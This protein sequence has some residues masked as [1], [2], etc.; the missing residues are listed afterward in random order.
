MNNLGRR[1]RIDFTD[2]YRFS[3]G[4]IAGIIMF[5]PIYLTVV[6]GFKSK[7]Q[8]F[9]NPFGL[10][11]PVSLEA[12]EA[13]LIRGQAYWTFLFNSVV[14]VAGVLL[15]ILTFSM[16]AG[17]AISRLSFRGNVLLYNFFIMG[18]LFPLTVA[19][20]PLYLQMKSLNLLG[21]R[22]GVILAEAAFNYPLSIF[23]FTGFFKEIPRDLQDACYIDGGGPLMFF[24]RILVPLSRP[25]I[26]TVSI[27]VFIMSWNQFLLPLLVLSDSGTFT[28]PLGV[29]QFQG[30][31]T[32]GWNF[33]MAFITISIL[34]MAVFYFTLQRQI[35]SGL[36]SGAL[37]G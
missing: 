15:L 33:I 9:I 16:T 7:G 1:K 36:T 37:K 19:I 2:L 29:M 6:G 28:I 26:A 24:Y 5:F 23:I 8:I 34:P 30:Q 35:V 31:F 3:I 13:I 14:V 20:L 32:T 12:Y 25:V 22:A 10:P 27:I 17:F 18:M 11:N 21:S 4:L